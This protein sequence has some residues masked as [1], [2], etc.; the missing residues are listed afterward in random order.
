MDPICQRKY[1]SLLSPVERQQQSLRER[2]PARGGSRSVESRSVRVWRWPSIDP[3][4]TNMQR[5]THSNYWICRRTWSCCCN[6]GVNHGVGSVKK[7]DEQHDD[8][9]RKQHAEHSCMRWVEETLLASRAH[10][11]ER[12]WG[13]EEDISLRLYGETMVRLDLTETRTAIKNRT[14]IL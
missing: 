14:N 6:R 5:Y 1:L 3:V 12:E 7:G 2:L 10:V 8:G 11:Q 4:M 9:G 13:W